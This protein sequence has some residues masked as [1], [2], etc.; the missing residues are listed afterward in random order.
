MEVAAHKM[1]A[2][3]I[4][5]QSALQKLKCRLSASHLR[6][7][8]TLQLCETKAPRWSVG[9]DNWYVASEPTA[10]HSNFARWRRRMFVGTPRSM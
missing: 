5:L 6:L 4:P 10:S 1:V 3:G 9:L 2:V 7:R 8:L